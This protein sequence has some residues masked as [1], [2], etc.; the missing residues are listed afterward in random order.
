MKRVLLGLILSSGLM[1]FVVSAHQATHNHSKKLVSVADSQVMYLGN[2]ALL[3]IHG[4]IKVLFDPFFHSHYNQYQLV[5][6]DIRQSIFAGKAPFND[7]NAIFI[8]HA[9][10][11]HFSAQDTLDYLSQNKAVKMYA[12]QQAV[13]QILKLNPPGELLKRISSVALKFGD[14]PVRLT[15]EGLIV[16]AVRI[17]HAG[18]PGRAEIENLVFRVSLETSGSINP[19]QTVM[20]MGD[21]DPDPSHYQPFTAHWQKRKTHTAFPPYWFYFSDQG[22]HIL[23]SILNVEKSIGVHVPVNVPLQLK[24][25]GEDYFNQPGETRAIVR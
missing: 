14:Q 10:G 15:S 18:W 6:E 23:D 2:E 1:A 7:V 11:D 12:P 16:E 5:P 20:H 4:E 17:P 9:H 22:K 13:Q 19:A 21:A 25:S 8:S 3:V 24:N